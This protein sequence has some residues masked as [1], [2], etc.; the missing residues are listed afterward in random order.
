MYGRK[1][2]VSG[3]YLL[4]HPDSGVLIQS[5]R[6]T[7]NGPSTKN[8]HTLETLESDWFSLCKTR[9]SYSN[10]SNLKCFL[11]LLEP[12]FTRTYRT[13]KSFSNYSYLPLLELLELKMLSRT[14]RTLT[15]LANFQKFEKQ[16]FFQ[17]FE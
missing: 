9:S 1:L 12:T 2:S 8:G 10:F 4:K 3:T 14:S 13:H 11:E 16:N 15:I 17:K 5:G 6:I 7:T